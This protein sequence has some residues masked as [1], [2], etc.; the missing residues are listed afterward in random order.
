MFNRHNNRDVERTYARVNR[1][2]CSRYQ[3]TKFRIL[4]YSFDHIQAPPMAVVKWCRKALQ[5]HRKRLFLTVPRTRRL[6]ENSVATSSTIVPYWCVLVSVKF[7]VKSTP[8]SEVY[9]FFLFLKCACARYV[10]HHWWCT[11]GEFLS[12]APRLLD[13]VMLPTNSSSPKV[14]IFLLVFN[15]FDDSPS[16]KRANDFRFSGSVSL[17]ALLPPSPIN[18]T[19]STSIALAIVLCISCFVLCFHLFFSSSCEAERIVAGHN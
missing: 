5:L 14:M 3:Y 19:S 18:K 12:V 4:S 9:E 10:I 11:N 7:V 17:P 13:V 8:I 15:R 1:V 2:F 16:L 6:L